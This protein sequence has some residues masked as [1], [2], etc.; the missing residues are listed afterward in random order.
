VRRRHNAVVV[1]A[2]PSFLATAAAAV[3]VVGSFAVGVALASAVG[4]EGFGERHDRQL[5]RVQ[6]EVAGVAAPRLGRRR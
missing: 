4:A 1:V 2:V 5:A 6:L 3:V